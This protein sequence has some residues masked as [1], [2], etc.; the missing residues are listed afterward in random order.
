[1]QRFQTSSAG[2]LDELLARKRAVD[3]RAAAS[4]L[5]AARLPELRAWQ[6]NRLAQTYADLRRD[7]QYAGAIE[8]FLNDLYGPHDLTRRDRELMRAWGLLKR[9]LPAMALDALGQAI[10]LEV[11][12]AE[13]DQLVT[14]ALSSWPV[15]GAG[16]ADAYRV[17][18]R[19]D[20]RERQIDLVVGVGEDLDRVVRHAWI[21]AALG[22]ARG[23]AHAAG[24]GVL[25]DFLERGFAAF[26]GMKDAQP[27]L[28]AVRE[29][30]MQ[31][32][33]ALFAGDDGNVFTRLSALSER[34][35]G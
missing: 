23:P 21:G 18:G 35:G 5:L 8:F 6:T 25:Q 19:R 33:Q 27:F 29:R 9:T 13:L 15:T 28:G 22:L 34:D 14:A 32:L 10:E 17:V 12:S 1:M 7:P 3:V 11:L 31:L 16:Y 24:F 4:S 20:A 2:N 30:E 26:A